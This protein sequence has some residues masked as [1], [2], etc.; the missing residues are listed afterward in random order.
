MILVV[1]WVKHFGPMVFDFAHSR[2]QFQF[3]E[4]MIELRGA[5]QLG[6]LIPIKSSTA[7]KLM[8]HSQE[9]KE[10]AVFVTIGLVDDCVKGPKEE[11][12]EAEQLLSQFGD[13]F[14]EPSGLPPPRNHDHAIPLI[15]AEATVMSGP[16]G[17]ITFRKQR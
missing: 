3:G 2:V 11:Q 8:S 13:V 5:K 1:D 4:L 16:T 7:S 6:K 14:A 15:K 17:T 12:L 10:E 9:V